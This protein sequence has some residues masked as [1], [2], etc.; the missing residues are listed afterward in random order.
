M[1]IAA[2][3]LSASLGTWASH[4]GVSRDVF[5]RIVTEQGVQPVG[6][7]GG[8]PIY[9]AAD[10]I[11]AL[12]ANAGASDDPDKLK[13]WERK[14]HYQAEH[15]KLRLQVERGELVP[16]IEVEQGH[17]RIFAIVTQA[18]DTLPDVLERDVGLTPLQLA[19]VEKHVDETREALYQALVEGED[20][21][22][23]RAAE[24]RA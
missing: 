2:A 16:A 11:R 23:D 24:D 7:R 1:P 12:L 9:G 8:H 14:A 13:P 18:F 20:D 4:A 6:K 15:E 17:G 21:G 3:E 5:R 22:A 10:V 19:R